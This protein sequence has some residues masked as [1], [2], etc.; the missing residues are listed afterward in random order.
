MSPLEVQIFLLLTTILT[1][2]I[3]Q[4]R[5]T[6][7]QR[8]GIT[9]VEANRRSDQLSREIQG[10][11]KTD[12]QPRFDVLK[13]NKEEL[14][15]KMLKDHFGVDTR[16]VV[17]NFQSR[18][19]TVNALDTYKKDDEQNTRLNMQAAAI[20]RA[21]RFREARKW[22][23][24][25]SWPRRMFGHASEEVRQKM[26]SEAERLNAE[27]EE[28]KKISDGK[29]AAHVAKNQ[30]TFSETMLKA[31]GDVTGMGP[32]KSDRQYSMFPGVQGQ[33]REGA[34]RQLTSFDAPP[35]E[36][37]RFMEWAKT[38]LFTLVEHDE[39]GRVWLPH[40]DVSRLI[41]REI[42]SMLKSSN[43]G[44]T[45]C[46]WLSAR[47]KDAEPVKQFVA[48]NVA[49]GAK[50]DDSAEPDGD[51]Q[52]EGVKANEG[53]KPDESVK[54]DGG[55]PSTPVRPDF[56]SGLR[57]GESG[58]EQQ[59]G[60]RE[61]GDDREVVEEG[62]AGVGLLRQEVVPAPMRKRAKRKE[63][64]TASDDVEPAAK[65]AKVAA[66]VEVPRRTL[67]SNAPAPPPAATPAPVYQKKGVKGYVYTPSP[68]SSP[69]EA[70]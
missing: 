31:L 68:P 65:K 9:C 69:N 57:H 6:A 33:H 45:T 63:P 54:S 35:A 41:A 46:T 27:K 25:T 42:I 8:W 60:A 44:R 21:R 16:Y 7:A 36:K 61:R 3:I 51:R 49:A 5:R 24:S 11:V 55:A 23:Y 52:N 43:F 4:L 47:R 22:C 29:M 50:A 67:R 10:F 64:A 34:H 1:L 59:R 18:E 70:K 15:G 53:T 20:W 17:T 28:W 12:I 19:R 40:T 62:G 39:T 48:T 26:E 14:G 66:E 30:S 56:S 32:A 2:S 38:N 58:R 13:G 37:R